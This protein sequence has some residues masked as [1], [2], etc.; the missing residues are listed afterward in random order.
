M[1]P[2]DIHRMLQRQ[3]PNAGLSGL[4][5]YAQLIAEWLS[6]NGLVVI[7]A[8]PSEEEVERVAAA[9]F[10]SDFPAK[11]G[12]VSWNEASEGSREMYLDTAR[13]ACAAVRAK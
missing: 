13:A 12:C 6:L 4:A 3:Y 1:N 5:A 9:I 7:P 10:D 2:N 8:R 11:D